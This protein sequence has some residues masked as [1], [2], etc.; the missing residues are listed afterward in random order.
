VLLIDT[1]FTVF[2]EIDIL[3]IG[4][5]LTSAK[6]GFF[7]APMRLVTF[8]Y[9]PSYALAV[10]TA[11][12]V[13]AAAGQRISSETYHT[14]MR[15]GILLQ[16]GIAAAVVVWAT[17]IVHLLLDARF[18]PSADVL[19]LL[20]PLVFLTG[21]GALTSM[22]VNYLGEA[23]RRVP[24]A[25]GTALVNAA[26]DLVLLPRIGVIGAAIGT[27]IAY[28]LYVI[29]HLWICTTLLDLDLS[30]LSL[31]LV[32]ALFASVVMGVVLALFGTRTLT[33][34]E[35]VAGVAT[36]IIVYAAVLFLTRELTRKDLSAAGTVLRGLRQR[37]EITQAPGPA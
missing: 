1:S 28:T 8:L 19:R 37:G 7:S 16:A 30:G 5:L 4:A 33:P 27:D 18:A 14:V 22:S 10:G 17:P 11:P 26:I 35:W 34:L 9:Y 21:I 29:G 24:I 2:N 12:R 6:V 13:A 31:T 20:G 3:L 15:A 25:I 36:G 32:R 23:R